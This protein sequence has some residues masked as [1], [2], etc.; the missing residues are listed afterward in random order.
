MAVRLSALCAGSPLPPGRL[1]VLNSV[2][3]RADPRDIGAARI[4]S[5]EKSNDLIGNRTRDLPACSIVPQPTT[6]PR[7]TLYVNQLIKC[8]LVEPGGPTPL[9]PKYTSGKTSEL[10]SCPFH[11]TYLPRICCLSRTF[12]RLDHNLSRQSKRRNVLCDQR[13][14]RNSYRIW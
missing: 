11:P 6:L 13:A 8:L 14:L 10:V 2:R 9:I 4:R 3:G 12:L 5:I 7:A 1:L